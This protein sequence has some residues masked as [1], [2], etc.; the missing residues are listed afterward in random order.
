MIDYKS[1]KKKVNRTVDFYFAAPVPRQSAQTVN[2]VFLYIIISMLRLFLVTKTFL[3]TV[4]S[5]T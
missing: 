4:D 2:V 5:R 1:P 3:D